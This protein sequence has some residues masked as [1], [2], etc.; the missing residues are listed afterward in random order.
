M[1]KYKWS[2]MNRWAGILNTIINNK[3]EF[4][5]WSSGALKSTSAFFLAALS[6]L[7]LSCFSL[8][9]LARACFSVASRSLRMPS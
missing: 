5:T 2:N 1:L 4:F 7:S 8:A 3:N 6:A 9:C